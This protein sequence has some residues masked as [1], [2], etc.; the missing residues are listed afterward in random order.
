MRLCA[1]EPTNDVKLIF[2]EAEHIP[3]DDIAA[4]IQKSLA[5]K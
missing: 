2:G 3:I 1:E 4:K 5:I